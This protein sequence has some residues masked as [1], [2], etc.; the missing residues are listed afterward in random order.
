MQVY[1]TLTRTGNAAANT[2]DDAQHGT[3]FAL[4]L[5]YCRQRVEGFSG[6][7]YR[8][9][10][11]FLF[12]DGI[13]ITKLRGGFGITRNSRQPFDDFC[14]QQ[15][16]DVGGSAAENFYSFK[17]KELFRFYVQPAEVGR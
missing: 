8:K 13:A 14:A 7:A 11:R 17:R 5:S 16:G 2:V 10:K 1:A 15:S 4:N 12:N 6:L 9:I 3:A